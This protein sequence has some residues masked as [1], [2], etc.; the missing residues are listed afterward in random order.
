M[1]EKR[2]VRVKLGVYHII[3]STGWANSEL[4]IEDNTGDVAPRTVHLVI[5]RPSDLQYIRARL[6]QIEE[7]WHKQLAAIKVTPSNG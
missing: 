4:I 3:A 2:R 6:D 7:A 5:D 1:N